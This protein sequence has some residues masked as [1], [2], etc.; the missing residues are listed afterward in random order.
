MDAHVT[1]QAALAGFTD[2][3]RQHRLSL[4]GSPPVVVE[5]WQ[6]REALSEGFDY[7][8]DV[9]CSD[10][11]L[12]L[13]DWLA[14]PAHLQTQDAD[15]GPILRSGLV[16]E[17]ELLGSDGGLA[18][19]RVRLVG[20]SW[21]L[22]QGRHSR[23]FQDLSVREIV[24]AV[25][26]DYAPQA[27]W[28]WSE[29][30]GDFLA[31]AR[32]RGYCVQYR[33][34]DMDFVARLLAEEGIGWRMECAE[35]APAGHRMVLFSDSS[36]QDRY[37]A[38]SVRYHRADATEASDSLQLLGKRRRLGATRLTLLSSSYA[39]VAAS[40]AQ[41]PVHGGGGQSLR[42]VYDPVGEYAFASAAE[43]ERHAGL[44]AQAHEARLSPW[45][46]EG[47]VR[48][49]RAGEWFAVSQWPH[50][51]APELLLTAIT[52]AAV[53]NLPLD[54]RKA[55]RDLLGEV[56]APLAIGTTVRE[57]AEA[58]GYANRFE[59]VERAQPWRPVLDDATG[60]LLN[61]R[62]TAPGYQTA[63]VVG[64][65][66]GVS[67][68]GSQEV[69]A[70]A[71]GRIRVK[72]HFQDGGG[73]SV[74]QDSTWLRVAQRYAGPGVGSQFLPRIGQEVLVGFLGGDIDRPVVLGALYNGRGEAGVPATPGGRSAETDTSLYAQAGDATPSAQA[75]LAG[76]HAPAWHAA[77]GGEDGHRHPGALWGVQSREWGG[78]G[79][80]RLVFDDS[81]QQ[82]RVQLATTQAHSQLTLGHLLHQA[83][84]YRGSF[85]GEGFELR[86]DAWGAVR[87]QRGLWLSSYG[88]AGSA[89]A[90]EA[91]QP[92]ALLKQ[93]QTLGRTFSQAAGTHATTKLAAHEGAGQANASLLI[94]D[95]APLQ[96]L[97]TSASTVVP[98]ASFDEAQHSAGERSA[99]PGDGK[100]PHS[101]DAL[102]GLAAPAG[103][104]LVAGQGLSWSV[105]ETL[106]LASGRHS[107][108]AVAGQARLH[109][110]QSIGLLAAAVQGGESQ[111][112]SLSVVSGE[113]ELDLQAQND[114]L[115]VQAQGA[116]K[117]VS[118]TAALE[119][120]AGKT[121]KL[122]TA[123]GA[124][125]TIEG[126]NISIAC[127]GSITV[128]ASKKSFVGPTTLNRSFVAWPKSELN[129]PCMAQAAATNSAFIRVD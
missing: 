23:I 39:R 56:D 125:I 18:R 98:G 22:S 80:N 103:I 89:P 128:H 84:N 97:L 2:E 31:Q 14:Q 50:G 3:S 57:R 34:S 17:A 100:V 111:A 126:G 93:L 94:P 67:P 32:P 83:D 115:R 91:T 63:R 40:T 70:D 55:A 41:L 7:W 90:G 48:G 29:E 5:R 120:A 25:F 43:A 110:G 20:W 82:L 119:L 73:E 74:S 45:E 129:A 69:H 72:F 37:A 76:G 12:P 87:G 113:G 81:D 92:V 107:E 59:A 86:S 51:E 1:L 52:H 104:G 102:L 121:I 11:G 116:L 44:M 66:A 118:A 68:S 42:E 47:S 105:G 64:P 58:V 117:M 54:A 53:N 33:E 62:P 114:A 106:T 46:G 16:N 38:G 15:G 124:S 109:S 8:V 49:F 61:P 10:A 127:P 13:Q 123:G 9:L 21:W 78:S 122:A 77:G 28:R 75:N 96:A 112:H 71:Q 88:H 26:A 108:G 35:E 19:Y 85:R 27:S 60:A 36:L 4:P 99:A 79:H 6:G 95:Q 101:G 24:E 65:D 30:V